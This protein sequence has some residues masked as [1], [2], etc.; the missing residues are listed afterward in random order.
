MDDEGNFYIGNK[1]TSS[2]TGQVDSFDIPIPTQV[3]GASKQFSA[4]EGGFDI[5]DPLQSNI[6][7][8]ILLK[9]EQMET[10]FLSLTVQ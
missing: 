2:S 3:G 1:K 9:V 6:R 4:E 10:H 8:G 5:I 7:R